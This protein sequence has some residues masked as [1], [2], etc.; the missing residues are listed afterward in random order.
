MRI[1]I[2]T[3][4]SIIAAISLTSSHFLHQIWLLSLHLHLYPLAFPSATLLLPFP[5][6]NPHVPDSSPPWHCCC[7]SCPVLF[8][9]FEFFPFLK[10]LLFSSHQ[11]E[12]ALQLP[13]SFFPISPDLEAFFLLLQVFS[14]SLSLPT[15]STFHFLLFLLSN[16]SLILPLDQW[17]G[18]HVCIYS[19]SVY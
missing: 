2:F 12:M 9:D 17:I 18:A 4:R 3:E 6:S 11:E 5:I 13:G 10:L 1:P 8:P 14:A 19:A 16:L 15:V 7:L